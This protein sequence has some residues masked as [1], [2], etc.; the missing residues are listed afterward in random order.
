MNIK[1]TPQQLNGTIEAIPSKS[2]AHRL[3]IAQK[4][5]ALQGGGQEDPL[6]IPTFSEDIDAT[7][8]C[9][10][11]LDEALPRF[12][13]RESGS[14]I[15]F[16]IPV[17][18][19][20]KDEAVFAGSGKLPQRP[21]SPLKEEMERHGCSFEM[22][23]TA[24]GAAGALNCAKASERGVTSEICRIR[25]RLQPGKYELAGNISSQFITGL[26][27]AL[28]LLNGDSS[29]Q[30]TTKL[31][32]A[33][34]VDLTLQVL[35]EFGIEIREVREKITDEDAN[36]GKK[37]VISERAAEQ[38]DSL[39]LTANSEADL[40]GIS[41]ANLESNSENYLIR[42][43]IPGNQIYRE[44]E[45]LKVEGDWSNAAFWLVAGALGGN[46]TCTGLNPDS[47]QRDKEI[48]TVL[49][50]MGAKIERE[51]TAYHI[52]GNDAPLHGETVSAAQF[53]D[54]VPVMA[55]A[56]TGASGTSSITNAE[57]LRI[58]E[59]DRLATV[60][61]FLTILGTDIRQTED[62]LIIHEN[63]NNT[64]PSGT[65]AHCPAPPL[66]GGTVSSHN[67]HR[68]AMAAAVASCRADGPIVITGA[69]AVKKSYPDFFTDFVKLGG[70]IE[71]LED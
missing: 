8:G 67:D 19:A 42:Y 28:P 62:G 29:L 63:K 10:A 52:A 41:E 30:L 7:K 58:K 40:E 1:I 46:I 44:P 23:A 66:S 21:L 24:K 22:L 14:T 59:S 20:L 55:V 15:R 47:T 60:C 17:A 50:K 43:E 5:A 2:H 56:M 45:G 6:A 11:Q 39:S 53:P 31:E 26:L 51:N 3:L 37:V 32:S 35:R 71:I 69:E 48:V 54:L 64:D 36:A 65:A 27:F 25:S 34:Y 12:D 57:R 38:A 16:M 9:L 70:K 4:L 13:C 68:I 61:D 33:G 49:E 18:M